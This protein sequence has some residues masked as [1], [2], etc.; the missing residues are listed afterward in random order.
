MGLSL[1]MQHFA[2]VGFSRTDALTILKAMRVRNDDD[3][4]LM[5]IFYDNLGKPVSECLHSGFSCREL[6]GD[7]DHGNTA[8][9][10]TDLTVTPQDGDRSHGN[11]VGMGTKVTVIPWEQGHMLR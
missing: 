10:G 5:T 9:M 1:P 7:G 3:T 4:C 8:V 6:H 11:T 2:T